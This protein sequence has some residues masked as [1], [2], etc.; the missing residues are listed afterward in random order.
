MKK[1][2]IIVSSVIIVALISFLLLG[3]KQT[4]W[5]IDEQ[6]LDDQMHGKEEKALNTWK[7]Y[8]ENGQQFFCARLFQFQVIWTA[9]SDDP[10]RPELQKKLGDLLVKA[11]QQG[12]MGAYDMLAARE[13]ELNKKREFLEKSCSGEWYSACTSIGKLEDESGNSGKARNY[14]QMSCEKNDFYA[15]QLL[16]KIELTNG[17]YSQAKDA[18]EKSCDNGDKSD[19]NMVGVVAYKQGDYKEARKIFDKVCSR[20]FEESCT[21]LKNLTGQ[22]R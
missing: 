6:A 9:K 17:N 3:K 16:G 19:C 2:I 21:N 14:Y 1:K 13:I 15:C 11:A 22:G 4:L 8:C 5:E 18:F 20:G 7:K 12:E 10:K